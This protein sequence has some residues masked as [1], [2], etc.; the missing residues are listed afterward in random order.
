M[1][2]NEELIKRYQEEYK[3]VE[4]KLIELEIHKDSFDEQYKSKNNEKVIK[5]IVAFFLCYT[6]ISLIFNREK[7]LTD[8][9][10]V[11]IIC[12]ILD[13]ILKES[14]KFIDLMKIK[15]INVL[16]LEMELY[17][18]YERLKGL[19]YTEILSSNELQT[20]EDTSSFVKIKK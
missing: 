15:K 5:E 4:K 3:V 2:K 8:I 7:D 10:I 14:Q 17:D 19:N 9:L 18:Y 12:S 13:I 6:G 16:D 20:S 1:E 11:P